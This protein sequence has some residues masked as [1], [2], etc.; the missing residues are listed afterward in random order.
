MNL[1]KT[2]WSENLDRLG[3]DLTTL[4]AEQSTYLGVPEAGPFKPDYYRY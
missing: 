4:T 2:F 3:I 1:I